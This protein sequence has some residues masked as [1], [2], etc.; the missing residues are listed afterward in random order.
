VAGGPAAKD[1]FKEIEAKIAAAPDDARLYF[2]KARCLTELGRYDEGYESAQ[3]GKQVLGQSAAFLRS[4]PL[5]SIELER[6]RVEVRLNLGRNERTPPAVGIALPLTFR[7]WARGDV[8]ELLDTIDFEIGY[9]GGKPN[10]AA[11]G[12]HQ[13]GAHANFGSLDPGSSYTTI[14]SK[15]IELIR[16]HTA[17]A[18]LRRSSGKTYL[19]VTLPGRSQFTPIVLSATPQKTVFARVAEVD[20]RRDVQVLEGGGEHWDF[21]GSQGR[22]LTGADGTVLQDAVAGPDGR[23]WV[24]VSHTP[25]SNP[26]K[27]SRAF[28]YCC[29]DGRWG[30]AEPPEGHAASDYADR[31]LVFL[32]SNEPAHL[33][34]LFDRPGTGSVATVTRLLQLH[35]GQWHTHPAEKLLQDEAT[36][37]LGNSGEA[38]AI[39][40]R[41]AGGKTTVHGHRISGPRPADIAGPYTL[42]TLDGSYDLYWAALSDCHRLALLPKESSDKGEKPCLARIVDV[43]RPD[44]PAV[45]AVA[46]PPWDWVDILRWSPQG[47]L[48]AARCRPSSV[49]VFALRGGRWLPIAE[50]SQDRSQGNIFHPRLTFR[51]D[52]ATIVTWEDFFPH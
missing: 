52:G 2:D 38:W 39:A 30:L 6:V 10:T 24:L 11:L 47:E 48:V 51:S 7:V 35:D 20:D 29:R 9:F 41:H 4:V 26:A 17:N 33:Q 49:Q 18:P 45:E 28:L 32:G 5:E 40:S 44:K 34:M 19:G 13:D 15:A 36:L 50:A 25:P 37:L 42:L 46:S 23:L 3:K 14:R 16:Q 43:S 8:R 1:R 12:Q 27:G 21:V 22:S 31:G